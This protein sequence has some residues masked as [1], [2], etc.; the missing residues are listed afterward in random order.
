M[1]IHDYCG[2]INASDQRIYFRQQEINLILSLL[3]NN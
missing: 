1:K 3:L 2:I